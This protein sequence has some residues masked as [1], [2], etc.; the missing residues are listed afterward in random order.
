MPEETIQNN[1]NWKNLAFICLSQCGV[2]FSF[3]FMFAFL[4][5]TTACYQPQ[6]AM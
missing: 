3:N 2:N 4:P 6:E 1:G 5:S